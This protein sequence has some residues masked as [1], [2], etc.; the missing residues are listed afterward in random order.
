MLEVKNIWVYYDKIKAVRNLSLTVKKGDF[1]TILGSNGAGKSSTLNAISVIVKAKKGKGHP[2]G[3]GHFEGEI[4]F[5]G[6]KLNGVT[7]AKIASRG[8]IQV[9]EG[10]KLWPLLTVRENLLLGAYLKK[11][12]AQ[13]QR[14]LEKA[15]D[16]FPVLKPRLNA[17][18][19]EMSGGQQQMVALARGLMAQ[20]EVLLFD[21]PSLGLSPI[22]RQN[23]AEKIREISR[24]G[25]TVLL[26]E[27]NARLGLMLASYGY[28]LENGEMSLEGKTSDLLDNEDVKRAYLGV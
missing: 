4:Y 11:D 12:R 22:L 25:T 21:E 27:Q 26:V 20:P 10:R 3:Q 7:A 24:D 6:E 18:A 16:L 17:K 28:V 15:L 2:K 8:I 5:K 13:V 9:P 19:R 23:L 14:S 1:V